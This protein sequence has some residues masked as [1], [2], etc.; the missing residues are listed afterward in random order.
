M[1]RIL[2]ACHQFFP[3]FY[4]GTETLTLEVA[5]EL[6]RQG[7]EVAI[8]TTEPILPNDPVPDSPQIRKEIYAG[9]TVWK[10]IIPDPGNP[11][12]RLDRESYDIHLINLFEKT[13]DEWNPD[14]VHVFHLMRLTKSFVNCIKKRGI[15]CYFTVTDFWLCCPTYQLIKNDNSLCCGPKP[16]TCF[17][18]LLDLYVQGMIRVPIHVKIARAYPRLAGFLHPKARDCQNTLVQRIKRHQSLLE[19]FDAVF[20]S[21]N[22]TRDVFRENGLMSNNE[23]IIPFPIPE[24]AKKVFDLEP[25]SSEGSLKVVFIG[26]LRHTKGPQILLNACRIIGNK[27][28]IEVF[29][30]GATDD[31]N[32]QKEL[33]RIAEGIDW[34][35][36]RGTFPQEMLPDVLK[37][38]HVVIIPS[39][40]YENT[41]LTAL[42]ALAARR[43][44]IVSDLG[45]LSGMVKDGVTGFTF[46]PG[47]AKALAQ[48]LVNLAQNRD[49]V[50]K[51]SSVVERPNRIVDYVDQIV[52]VYTG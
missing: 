3:R 46:P 4:T 33:N 37:E 39:I 42:S 17:S 49:L 52:Q 43:V 24:R 38:S 5:D 14:I 36:F 11:V 16:H 32:F 23:Y 2:L 25:V 1:T 15:P 40:W 28:S 35:Y 27:Q 13:L 10:L 31:S 34:V 19:E 12:E 21:N 22:F 47:N 44:L 20:W 48:I 6:T 29:I 7:Y 9:Y 18:C 51:I 41:P 50:C 30:W 26:T 45:G 8:L